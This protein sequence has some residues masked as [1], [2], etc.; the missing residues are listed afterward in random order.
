[1]VISLVDFRRFKQ[2]RIV[3]C[4]IPVFS[5]SV[6]LPVIICPLSTIIPLHSP[7]SWFAFKSRYIKRCTISEIL[8]HSHSE[9][10]RYNLIHPSI[11][12]TK[13]S[14]KEKTTLE[15][16]TD[17]L[18]YSLPGGKYCEYV[19]S[20]YHVARFRYKYNYSILSCKLF[21]VIYF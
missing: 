1:M 3:C 9:N 15:R 14:G 17:P 19:K 5:V 6:F 8:N 20:V 12:K 18:W 13:T 16:A 2:V 7:F 21:P 10:L 4:V 11:S